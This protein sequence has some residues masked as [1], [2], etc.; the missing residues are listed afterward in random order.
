MPE[1]PEVE[2]V[3][4][5]LA[6]WLIQRTI[7]SIECFYPPMMK[8]SIPQF[9]KLANGTKLIDISRRGKHLI[10]H[11]NNDFVILS[12]LRMEGK[13][14]LIPQQDSLPRY[15]VAVFHLDDGH[16]LVYADTRKFGTLHIVNKQ[17]LLSQS[18]LA[19]LGIEP[20][21]LHNQ[22]SIKD[23]ILKRK[24]GIKSILLDQTIIA[25]VGNIYADEILF[26]SQ[27][28]PETPGYLLNDQSLTRLL[29]ETK[30]VIE[31]AVK[32]GGTTI[33]TY[34][35]PSGIDGLFQHKLLAY[36]RE[37]FPCSRCGIP[38]VKI[39][40][41]GRGTTFCRHCQHHQGLP[42]IVGVTGEIA[43]GKSTLLHLAQTQGIHTISS[44]EVVKA[45]YSKKSIQ[46][47]LVK[48]FGKQAIQNHIVNRAHILTQI[49]EDEAKLNKLES[50]LHPLVL[51]SIHRMI[52]KTKHPVVMVEMPLLFK[53]GFDTTCN[54][55]IGI[56]IQPSIQRERLFQRNPTFAQLLL[57][58]NAF[59]TFKNNQNKVNLHISNQTSLETFERK[60]HQLIQ[61]IIAA[62]SN[63]TTS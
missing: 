15:T 5:T 49:A 27:I 17:K 55:I 28:H 42:W 26:R 43:S 41:H 19:K 14:F 20:S 58:L 59:N 1:L 22:Q 23:Q 50:W 30:R 37:G 3:R 8:P 7:V 31:A 44:D 46:L 13:Y 48:L 32:A 63:Q 9:K 52:R 60:C 25:G 12:H 16:K 45:L 56:G 29:Q 11:L 38:L 40:S 62:H 2:T 24:K 54:D 51:N 6:Q 10:F 21:D 39:Q 53:A 34:R 18:P 57:K 4:K 61:K 33:R 36:G 35:S 47:K